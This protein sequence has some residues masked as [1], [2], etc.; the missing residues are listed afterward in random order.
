MKEGMIVP[1]IEATIYVLKTIAM[2]E[3]SAGES[4]IKDDHHAKGDVTGVIG[5]TGEASGTLSVSFSEASITA[6]VSRMFGEEIHTLN[7]EV[8]DAVGEIANMISGQARRK[9]EEQGKLIHGAIPSVIVGKNHC[10]SHFTTHPVVA[11]PFKTKE[12]DFTLEV[13]LEN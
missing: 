7:G 10:L 3:V 4:Y 2:T 11:V 9:L 8:E 5:L 6:I 13:C 1:F 12:G